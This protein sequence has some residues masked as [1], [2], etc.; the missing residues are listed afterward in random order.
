MLFRSSAAFAAGALAVAGAGVLGVAAAPALSGLAPP[1]VLAA[2]PS[3]LAA[4]WY[5]QCFD[6]RLPVH[7]KASSILGTNS[8]NCAAPINS[9]G[10]LVSTNRPAAK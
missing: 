4:A 3:A 7:L 8:W 6:A 1:S 2:P 9:V 10:S 5:F